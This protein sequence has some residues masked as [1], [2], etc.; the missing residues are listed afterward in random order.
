MFLRVELCG[1]GRCV[2]VKRRGHVS[3]RCRV[4]KSDGCGDG[5][6]SGHDGGM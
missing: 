5:G 6:G 4:G 1:F 2:T 3:I